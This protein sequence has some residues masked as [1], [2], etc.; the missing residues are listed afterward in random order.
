MSRS[1]APQSLVEGRATAEG[2]RRFRKRFESGQIDH[3][4]RPL[5]DGLVVSS[6]GLGTYL[7]ECDDAE[8]SRYTTTVIAALGKGVN[9]LD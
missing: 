6:L 2:T 3:F 8:D 1:K 7:G 5:S 9:L 4:F